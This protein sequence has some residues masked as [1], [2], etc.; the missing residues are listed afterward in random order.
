MRSA[1]WA[2]RSRLLIG[3]ILAG[4]SVAA[5]A[6]IAPAWGAGT[7]SQRP[8]RILL[9]NDDG[10]NAHGIRAVHAALEAAGHQVTIVAPLANQS[11]AS[12]RVSFH[13]T[14]DV[15]QQ[16]PGVYSVAGTPGDSAEFGIKAVFAD[17][18]PDLVISGT[19][20]GQNV[21]AATIH[22]GTV[23]AA[24]TALCDGVPAIAVSTELDFAT[25]EGPYDE[26]A[27]F[28]VRLVTTLRDRANG[29]RLLPDDVGL[30]V[31]YP[32]V[33]DGGSPAGTVFTETGRGFVDLTYQ[34]SLPEVGQTSTH[35]VRT[36][37]AP[38]TVPGSDLAVL[39]ENK[40]AV[41][42]MECDYDAAESDR[43]WIPG[44]V[45]SMR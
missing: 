20:A 44:M 7:E 23:G 22:S 39:T 13:G 31:N 2:G 40:I 16:A 37:R 10:W 17:N 3:L 29:G 43:A 45:E 15:T 14:L 1:S 27:A 41:S 26:T 19:N 25:R 8:L 18:P 9:T 11:G 4:C 38:E 28:V 30:N 33:E 34:G 32:L 35:L 6:V 12:A 5:S 42:A 21:A 36:T 24:V